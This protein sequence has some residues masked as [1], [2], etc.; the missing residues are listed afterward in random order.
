MVRR[1]SW[2]MGCCGLSIL[3]ASGCAQ[4]AG[5]AEQAQIVQIGTTKADL[6]G[7][8]AEYRALHPRLEECLG[9]MVRFA[10]QPDG[11]ALGKQLELGNIPYAFMS[12]GEYAAVKNPE[13]L[14]LVASGLNALGKTSRKAYVVVK[15]G[16]HVKT[17]ADC[18][19]K[20]FAFGTHGDL[21]TDW[22]AQ[23]TLEGAGV[24]VK[25][26]LLELLTP[27]PLALDGRLY[28]KGDTAR[29]IAHD[30]TVNAGVID[31]VAYEQM[32]DS[33][34]NLI[35]GPS[36][37]QFTIVGETASVPEV[38]LVAGP[39][40]DA[41]LTAKLKSFLIDK[42]KDDKVVCEQL[43]VKGFAPADKALY[44]AVGKLLPRP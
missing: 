21:L 31:E 16:S 7:M 29:T 34:G 11:A 44:D 9:R 27:P 42:V 19:G 8:P 35:T 14:T 3:A 39:A 5:K 20:R 40:A 43:G 26:L 37:S 41:E 28:L 2:V 36:K 1:H 30:L 24:P 13:K 18:A 4:K 15:A 32:P 22:A 12:A 10:A 23:A 38:V 25:K 6:F 17:I 33:G